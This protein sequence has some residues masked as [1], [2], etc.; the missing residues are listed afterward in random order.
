[1]ARM[2]IK[3]EQESEEGLVG[4]ESRR[5]SED[6]LL[7]RAREDNNNKSSRSLTRM[8]IQKVA[9]GD[10]VEK[11]HPQILHLEESTF[12]TKI[13]VIRNL[14]QEEED[15]VHKALY[16]KGPDSEKVVKINTDTIQRGSL[17]TLQPRE[18][19]ND[20]IIHFYFKLLT[21]RDEMMCADSVRRRSHFFK[22]FFLR[23]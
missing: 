21:N 20:E 9:K 5:Q 18:W 19:L 10:S 8:E 16:K 1:M 12:T 3:I 14:T 7:R 2:H 4:N 13:N 15:I 23:R 6:I 22:S 17:R 11:L